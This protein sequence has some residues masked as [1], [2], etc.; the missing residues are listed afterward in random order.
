MGLVRYR[1]TLTQM[2]ILALAIGTLCSLSLRPLWVDEIYQLEATRDQP[3]AAMLHSSMI[4]PGGM[5]L[6]YTAQKLWLNLSG[7][8]TAQ[9]RVPAA[10]FGLGSVF[11][12]AWAARLLAMNPT[13]VAILG[14][15]TPLLFRYATEARPYSQGLFFSVLATAL[16]LKW[17]QRP[18]PGLLSAY[19]FCSVA[20]IYSQPFSIFVGLSHAI[21]L[22]T[23]DRRRSLPIVL[24]IALTGL[25]YEPWFLLSR[26]ALRHEA[27]PHLMF[28]SWQQISPLM[29]L[30]EISGGGYV[31]SICL[32]ILAIWGM[33]QQANSLLLYWTVLPSILAI[34]ADAVFNY[35]FAIRQLIFVL[36]PLLLA[37]ASA[38]PAKWPRHKIAAG[39]AA[40]YILGALVKDVRWQADH[41]E[42]W[43]QAAAFIVQRVESGSG[44]VS[45]KPPRD[46]PS[47]YFFQPTLRL[48]TCDAVARTAP[49]LIAVS[50]YAELSD[51]RA[52]ASGQNIGNT[53]MVSP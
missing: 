30:R 25:T 39:L 3:F 21:W 23:G 12:M 53:L 52:A 4:A 8:S 49:T 46:A 40:V 41:K 10:A 9:A 31:C 6:A 34:G 24:A 32:V 5:P 22:L 13:L 33:R 27:W 18:S 29:L 51:R 7:F 1:A 11:A 36:P 35:F 45:F 48:R 2:L 50:P 42:D 44:C 20:G 14:L 43:A 17:L 26:Q 15:L 28:F 16:L 37:A 19:F 47:Y 38:V